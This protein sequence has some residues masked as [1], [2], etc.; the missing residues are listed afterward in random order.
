MRAAGPVWQRENV[1]LDDATKKNQEF[2]S[3][4]YRSS[5]PS[6]LQYEVWLESRVNLKT[7]AG[8]D[9]RGIGQEKRSGIVWRDGKVVGTVDKAVSGA[10]SDYLGW[11]SPLILNGDVTHIPFPILFSGNSLGHDA[12]YLAPLIFNAISRSI[13]KRSQFI[14]DHNSEPR[15]LCIDDGLSIQQC[16][17]GSIL[18]RFQRTQSNPDTSYPN[19]DQRPIYHQSIQET[20]AQLVIGALLCWAGCWIAYNRRGWGWGMLYVLL[21]VLGIGLIMV[22]SNAKR[23]SQNRNS[24]QYF[25]DAKY[26]ISNFSL[27]ATGGK[28]YE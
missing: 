18:A 27:Y 25:H 20:L 8:H 2:Q 19:Q 23:E 5:F 6:P 21:M 28:R 15:S 13:G 1:F 24:R 4:V 17:V 10:S 16:S 26:C 12:P 14:C 11:R 3:A 7:V 22:G 9:E